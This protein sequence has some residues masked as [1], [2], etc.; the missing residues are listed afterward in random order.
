MGGTKMTISIGDK[1]P[2]VD[3]GIMT[4][5][6]PGI[7]DILAMSLGPKKILYDFAKIELTDQW[8]SKENESIKLNLSLGVHTIRVKYKTTSHPG[9]STVEVV[10]N[11]MKFKILPPFSFY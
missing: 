6:G 5:D 10:S 7:I 3:L 11:Q 4:Q 1:I 2:N 8:V 9:V